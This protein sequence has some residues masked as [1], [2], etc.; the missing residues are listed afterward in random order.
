MQGYWRG[1]GSSPKKSKGAFSFVTVSEKLAREV[2]SSLAKL[3]L[4]CGVYKRKTYYKQGTAYSM[5]I[6]R[7][8]SVKFA[9]I[10]GCSEG[11]TLNDLTEQCRWF[12]ETDQ[13][14]LVQITDIEE[15]IYEGKVH[16]LKISGKESYTAN[17][18][19]VHNCKHAIEHGYKILVDTSIR[20]KHVGLAQAGP[21]EG[22]FIPCDA[23]S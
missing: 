21:G 9:E 10:F 17:G 6:P 13:Y 23:R 15:F 14:F 4:L 12:A 22:E 8:Q 1:D 3:G 5:G 20:C 18:V 2:Q 16:N 7:A 11:L 19:A